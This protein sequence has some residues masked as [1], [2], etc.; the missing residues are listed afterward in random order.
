MMNYYL[1]WEMI[2]VCNSRIKHFYRKRQANIVDNFALV[3]PESVKDEKKITRPSILTASFHLVTTS[4][5]DN[6][7]KTEPS[8]KCHQ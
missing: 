5:T 6:V 1:I 2:L 4:E 7:T 8:R 3:T